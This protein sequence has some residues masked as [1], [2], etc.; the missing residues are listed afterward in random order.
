ISTSF[1]ITVKNIDKK[2]QYIR[3]YSIIR[4]SIDSTPTVT[5]VIDFDTSSV[6]DTEIS[7]IDN[8]TTGDTVDPTFLLYVG[9]KAIIANCIATK[10][11]T[12]FPGD[13]TYN[14][15]SIFDLG[16]RG[17]NL[18]M[19]PAMSIATERRDISLPTQDIEL[20]YANQL[21][22][23]TATFKNGET[24]RLGCRFQYKTGE[25]SEPIWIDDKEYNYSS[26]GYSNEKLHLGKLVG[27]AELK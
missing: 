20:N 8:N 9:G 27:T 17:D 22:G 16:I 11:N 19:Y 1:K 3:V 5:R 6:T 13:I 2:F 21:S 23:N 15:K 25:W 4:T 18:K 7:I 10:D 12:L 26:L 14:R 24:Y